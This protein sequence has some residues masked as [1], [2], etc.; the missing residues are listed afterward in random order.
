MQSSKLAEGNRE[1][2]STVEL[3][4]LRSLQF[5]LGQI[6]Q[7]TAVHM[8]VWASLGGYRWRTYDM[9]AE[10][11]IAIGD[12]VPTLSD[13]IECLAMTA[14]VAGLMSMEEADELRRI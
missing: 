13:A 1:A 7:R 6:T 3:L 8:V 9:V 14:V 5:R 10:Y 12:G 11:R 2:A 4:R